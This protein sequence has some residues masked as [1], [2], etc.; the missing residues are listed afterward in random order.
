MR[1]LLDL[2]CKDG[3]RIGQDD[4]VVIKPNLQWYNQGAPNL[5]AAKALVDYIFDMPGFAGEVVLAE[6][7]HLGPMPSEKGGW[8]NRFIRNSDLPGIDNY[9]Q[10]AAALKARYGRRFS[11]CHWLDMDKGGRRVYGPEDGPGYVVCDGTGGVEFV[12]ADN[13]L[14]GPGRRQTVMTYP[15]FTTDNGT[16]VDL[17]HGIW[18][19]GRYEDR[20][21]F[22]NLAALN[23]HSLYCGATSAVKNIFGVV[24]L[25]GGPDPRDNGRLAG[26]YYNFHAFA[27]DRWLPGP[28]PGAMGRA[29][30]TFLARIRRPDMNITTAHWVGLSSRVNAP[31]A[32]AKVLLAS[33]DP[34]ALDYH[35]TR[36]VLYPNSR[37]RVHDP[38]RKDGPLANDLHACAEVAGLVT[39]SSQ[40]ELVSLHMA[41]GLIA[42][43]DGQPVRARIYWGLQ[44][45]A[46]AKYLVFRASIQG[47]L[48]RLLK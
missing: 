6:N 34:V 37:I 9:N 48:G 28:A 4:L 3:L 33:A 41:T 39:C 20:L 21:R 18:R 30:G 42:S 45:R 40:I 24:D 16:V 11:V 44:P 32:L 25:S 13:G 47:R 8:A 27:F 15:I 7:N 36:Y 5:A 46:L 12:G 17:R 31:V 26:P 43:D 22:I 1:A 23:H 38:D 2:V 35:A 19:Q 14:Q 10:L 29:V